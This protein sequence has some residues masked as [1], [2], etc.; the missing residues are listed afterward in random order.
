MARPNDF[1]A[2]RPQETLISGYMLKKG[3]GGLGLSGLPLGF[4]GRLTQRLD[5]GGDKTRWVGLGLGCIVALYY[6]SST[7]Y[8]DHEHVRHLYSCSDDAT[9]PQVV[10]K[11][12]GEMIYYKD[13]KSTRLP[14]RLGPPQICSWG[15]R[16]CYHCESLWELRRNL[17]FLGPR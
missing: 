3:K 7:S 5:K 8:Q 9:E 16:H 13:N 15:P 6:R 12:N 14:S 11:G 10:L 1:A 17:M 2:P 4:G